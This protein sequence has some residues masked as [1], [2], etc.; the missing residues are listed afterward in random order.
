[1]PISGGIPDSVMFA[2]VGRMPLVVIAARD[3]E[4]EVDWDLD[5]L[6]LPDSGI[7]REVVDD[8]FLSC[9]ILPKRIQELVEFEGIL[10]LV[11]AGYGVGIIPYI[12]WE[13]SQLSS[14][15]KVLKISN[16]LPRLKIGVFSLKKRMHLR[17][18]DGF[19]ELFKEA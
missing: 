11:S 2:P 1:M 7:T 14:H 19:F 18:I 4:D 3:H 13:Q 12:V 5:T 10:S 9:G 15:T 8:W 6:L 16:R 17:R